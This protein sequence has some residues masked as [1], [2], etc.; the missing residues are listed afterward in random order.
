MTSQPPPSHR[1]AS[2]DLLVTWF[3][4]DGGRSQR[5]PPSDLLSWGSAFHPHRLVHCPPFWPTFSKQAP[6]THLT[7]L[8]PLSPNLP[9]P[10]RL[11]L[12]WLFCTGTLCDQMSL[13]PVRTSGTLHPPPVLTFHS[14]TSQ[15]PSLPVICSNWSLLVAAT[16][17]LCRLLPFPRPRPPPGILFS[18]ACPIA[19]PRPRISTS[20]S[21]PWIA[22]FLQL[23]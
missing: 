4:S 22:P 20:R 18:A 12:F 3:W 7:E 8:L 17:L 11:S 9:S 16:T 5:T 13:L 1:R 10:S 19:W 2:T 23:V 6:T 15:C 21:F 14:T